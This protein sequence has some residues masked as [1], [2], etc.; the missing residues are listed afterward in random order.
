MENR[1]IDLITIL[2]HTAGGKTSLAAHLAHRISGEVIS[3][4]SRQVYRGMNIGTGKDYDD[5]L[6]GG[7]R[8]PSHLLD[9]VEAGEEYNVYQFQQDFYRSYTDIID[10]GKFPVMCGG[11]G[12]YIESV[13]RNYQMVHVPIN[14]ELREELERKD[15]DEL[16]GILEQYGP[17]HNVTDSTNKKRLIRAVEI[18][19]YQGRRVNE[20]TKKLSLHPLV[21][22]ISYD[23]ETRRKKITERLKLR[24]KHGMIEEVAGLL[25][26]GIEPEKMEYYGLEY[27][28]VSQFIRQILTYDEMFGRLNTAIHQ[29]AKRQMTYFRGMERRGIRIHW[30]NGNMTM[31]KK[32]NEVTARY[33]PT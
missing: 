17:L 10:R 18:A 27:R 8:I 6:V 23:R 1:V 33:D 9:I 4:D 14:R 26:Q 15:L 31:K 22:G 19:M 20:P 24:L 7:E 28:Y 16:S 11:S 30:L 21:I 13:L 29:F 25:H 12:L 32:M 5:Y 2:G 3:A